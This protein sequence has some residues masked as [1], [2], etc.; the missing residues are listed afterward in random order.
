MINSFNNYNFPAPS[1]SQTTGAS[2][3]HQTAAN[4]NTFIVGVTN[5][6]PSIHPPTEG[7][8]YLCE[9]NVGGSNANESTVAFQCAADVPPSKYVFVQKQSSGSLTLCEL[10]VYAQGEYFS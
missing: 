9:E 3:N 5:L 6:D 1:T 10:E 7:N 8:Y 2:Q 4:G